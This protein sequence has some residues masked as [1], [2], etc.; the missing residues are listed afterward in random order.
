M[1]SWTYSI[2]LIYLSTLDELTCSRVLDAVNQKSVYVSEYCP[3]MQYC[4]E[5]THVMCMFYNKDKEMGPHCL[6]SP[7]ITITPVLAS[8]LLEISNAIR[9]KVALGREK[10]K[11]GKPLPRGFGMLRL[12]WDEELATFA[13]VLANQCVLRHDIC[14]ATKTFPDPGQT[15]G[16]VRYTYPDWNSISRTFPSG[17]DNVPGL[18]EDKLIYAIK[19]STK[20][21][22]IQKT[23]VTPEMIMNYPDWLQHPTK[24]AGKLYLEMITGHA[25][26]MGCG[27]SAYTEYT[28][29]NNFAAMSYNS[30]Q[31]ICNFSARPSPGTS[32]YNTEPPID[33]PPGTQCGCPPGF[34]EDE[35]CLCN[36]S[37]NYRPFS[38]DKPSCNG[39]NC[40][41]PIVLLPIIAMEDAPPHKLKSRRYNNNT[42]DQFEN[43]DI[44]SNDNSDNSIHGKEAYMTSD[45]EKTLREA[46]IN[47]QQ[48]RALT[49]K[50]NTWK[51]HNGYFGKSSLAP[52]NRQTVP[53][54]TDLG[55]TTIKHN[56][57]KSIFSNVNNFKLPVKVLIKKDV[58]PRKDFAKVQNLVNKYLNKKRNFTSAQP[59]EEDKTRIKINEDIFSNDSVSKIYAKSTNVNADKKVMHLLDNLEQEVDHINFDQNEKEILDS[60]LRKI[61]GRIS[62]EPKNLISA[63]KL[64]DNAYK[65]KNN[66]E[67]ENFIKY[68]NRVNEHLMNVESEP[69]IYLRDT[70]NGRT[71]NFDDRNYQNRLVEKERDYED[72]LGT[73]KKRLEKPINDNV[74]DI[75]A[76]LNF[77][78]LLD[79]N[80]RTMNALVEYSHGQDNTDRDLMN[81]RND[82]KINRRNIRKNDLPDERYVSKN[83]E[84]PRQ[85]NY[86]PVSRMLSDGQLNYKRRKYYQDKLD[87]LE[88][89]LQKVRNHRRHNKPNENRQLR[90]FKV[91]RNELEVRPGQQKIRKNIFYIPDR[92]R[93]VHGI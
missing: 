18:T 47:L 34:N 26:H 80:T 73:L 25:T 28:Y 55:R 16:L 84:D 33:S 19:Q 70:K 23:S 56:A 9:S 60:K 45:F 54:A 32:V 77:N 48:A 35:D 62:N 36:E 89:K 3:K 69:Q 27:I 64:E 12:Q 13:Q 52:E 93:S 68:E 8:K 20:S 5:G 4:K 85:K 24:H 82:E 15:A 90:P 42:D 61:Y 57:R 87:Y 49:H 66:E 65:S 81:Y 63:R 83:Y 92:A 72:N 78:R 41:P 58:L 17:D 22:Y 76:N 59:S 31:V 10:G 29:R 53:Q 91:D 40:V 43:M 14:R 44:F 51:I 1:F 75:N 88:R 67:R 79:R 2:L 74:Y 21:W 50:E 38:K 7:N 30:V 71:L 46:R 37:F 39:K 11:D 86:Y 6:N